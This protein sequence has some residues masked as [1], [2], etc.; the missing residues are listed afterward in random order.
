MLREDCP[1]PCADASTEGTMSLD[2]PEFICRF[3]IHVL[4]KGY[5]RVHYYGLLASANRAANIAHARN[6]LA[7]RTPHRNRITDRDFLPW[8]FSAAGRPSTR[9]VSSLPA[10]ENLHR[11]RRPEDVGLARQRSGKLVS[12]AELFGQSGEAQRRRIFVPHFF[13]D[14]RQTGA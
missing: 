12:L 10:A 7:V 9:I 5:H 13:F 11:S 3:L 2:T 6:L 8:R 1:D 4:P 14:E